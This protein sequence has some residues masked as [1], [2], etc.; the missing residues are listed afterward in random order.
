MRVEAAEDLAM[1]L[2]LPVPPNSPEDGVRF[3]D[4]RSYREFFS[5]LDGRFDVPTEGGVVMG[6]PSREG[7]E[8]HEV[9]SYEA[10]FVP[11]VRDFDRLDPRFRLPDMVWESV[12]QYHDYGFAVFKLKGGLP[13]FV[14]PMAFEFPQRHPQTL[15]F[16][17]LHV[18]DGRVHTS[19]KFDH[20]L[21]CQAPR[22][23]GPRGWE[24][25]RSSSS[26]T[27][28]DFEPIVFR[29]LELYRA[30]LRGWF[31]NRDIVGDLADRGV[32]IE[33]ESAQCADNLADVKAFVE[34][35]SERLGDRPEQRIL[36]FIR[37]QATRILSI[38]RWKEVRSQHVA[39]A[40]DAAT[41]QVR[42]LVQHL[43]ERLIEFQRIRVD[44]SRLSS[45]KT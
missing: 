22:E 43:G 10:S 26:D 28:S 15:F 1:V 19:A 31:E 45:R 3:I 8:V 30:K 12:P 38:A 14:E 13:M 11:T 24:V 25:P 36:E 32:S 7:L 39:G 6:R 29:P 23:A 20:V 33:D 16:P 17:T 27:I 18:H 34:W 9:G 40:V 42:N 21:Y 2:P 44:D 37:A 35:M 41:S 4:M 5:W